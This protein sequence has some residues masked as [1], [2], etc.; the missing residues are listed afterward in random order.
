MAVEVKVTL[1]GE[2]S[3]LRI[4][5]LTEKLFKGTFGPWQSK[6]MAA[7]ELQSRLNEIR[8]L[9]Q[10]EFDVDAIKA[11]RAH[12]TAAGLLLPGPPDHV[13]AAPPA[14]VE[15][16]AAMPPAVQVMVGLLTD[17]AR[18][19]S[20]VAAAIEQAA[21]VLTEEPQTLPDARVADDWL[22]RWRDAAGGVGDKDLQKLWGRILAGE[23]KAPGQFSLRTLEFVR[24]LNQREAELITRLAGFVCGSVVV[25]PAVKGLESHGL[26]LLDQIALSE[27]G[28]ISGVETGFTWT[29]PFEKDQIHVLVCVDKGLVIAT[30]EAANSLVVEVLNVSAIGKELMHLGGFQANGEYLRALGTAIAK[31][32][33]TVKLADVVREVGDSVLFRNAQ[34]IVIDMPSAA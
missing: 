23:V 5:E 34:P 19:Q 15:L 7:A 10:V 1:P 26:A 27:L 16:L 8:A 13:L 29:L 3:V 9:A 31:R 17:E 18:K 30:D 28:V 14:T 20:N 2:E 11:G 22:F 12:L 24:N 6:R 4:L 33:F 21:A 32:G 25:K